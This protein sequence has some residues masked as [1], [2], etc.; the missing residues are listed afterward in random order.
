MHPSQAFVLAE[1]SHW[2]NARLLCTAVLPDPPHRGAACRLSRGSILRSLVNQSD[3]QWP[4]RPACETGKARGHSLSKTDLADVGAQRG[5]MAA[6]DDR[7]VGFVAGPSD[8]RWLFRRTLSRGRPRPRWRQLW[9]LVF[10]ALNHAPHP[11]A[12][13][14]QRP[15]ELGHPPGDLDFFDFAI[16]RPRTDPCG[17]EEQEC[18]LC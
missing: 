9:V 1:Y 5:F 16:R 8:S 10:R 7:W 6:E 4:S 11:R 18:P 3:A 13:I 12:G 15:S 2:A 17:H 14:G